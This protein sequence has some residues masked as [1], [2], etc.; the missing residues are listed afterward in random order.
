MEQ[1]DIR[2]QF[3]WFFGVVE[4][5]NDPLQL[6]RVRV[7]AFGYHSDDAVNDLPVKQ[8][9]WAQPIQGIDSAAIS[10]IGHS[11][12]G[13]VEGTWVFGFF[14]DGQDAQRPYIIGSMAGIPTGD[15][16]PGKSGFRDP[17]GKY[18]LDDRVG[19]PDTPRLAR[20]EAEFAP[21]LIN[22]RKSRLTNVE[23]AIAPW[24]N[25]AA[26]TISSSKGAGGT[27]PYLRETWTEVNP[28]YDGEGSYANK[29]SSTYPYNHVY[30]GESGNIEEYDETP[31]NTRILQQHASG[32]FYEIQHSGTK[33][34]KVVNDNYTMIMGDDKV[35]I[36]GD[37]NITVQG[38]VN[39]LNQGDVRHEVEGDLYTTVKGDRI[40]KIQGNDVLEVLSDHST[41][42]N[43]NKN[44]RVAKEKREITDFT[45]TETVGNNHI[46]TIKKNRR[47]TIGHNWADT[48]T[49]N[50]TIVGIVNIDIGAGKNMNAGAG[51]NVNL[52]AKNGFATLQTAL[53]FTE[54]IGTSKAS[55]TGT[56][57]ISTTGTHWNHTSTANTFIK[58][59]RIDLNE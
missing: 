22:R 5:R 31:G 52:R 16:A 50:T 45:H 2:S 40:T 33:T 57:W 18:P 17:Q 15:A 35:F 10:G 58:A 12:T 13:L 42:I 24:A 54:T 34:T 48:T 4:D 38:N 11:P 20:S 28:R 1:T 9:P 8:L 25:S 43:G 41:Q 27:Y 44:E 51:M 36:S 23:I 6:G 7:R 3:E 59:A 14:A 46:T 29:S 53:T 56:H 39:I 49:G 21:N 55:S 37:V 19:E 30:Q 26:N 32:T 47:R